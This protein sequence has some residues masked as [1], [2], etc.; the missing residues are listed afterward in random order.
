MTAVVVGAFGFYFVVLVESHSIPLI[1]K[2]RS[3]TQ[4][5]CRLHGKILRVHFA[6]QQVD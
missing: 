3:D 2:L 1:L 4:S 6:V 5:T